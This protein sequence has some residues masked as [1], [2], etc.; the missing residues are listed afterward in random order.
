MTEGYT[1]QQAADKLGI[2]KQAMHKRVLRGTQAA[3][4]INGIWTVYLQEDTPGSDTV[5]D[6]V[7]DTGI[8]A[9]I[10]VLQS[11]IEF[12]REELKRKD[13]L[14]MTI[15]QRIPMLAAPKAEKES[16]FK[17]LFRRKE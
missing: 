16:F 8:D 11:E 13:T 9:V 2:S 15:T 17:G 3:E 12:L 10:Q 4:K 1:I 5:K 14:L 7:K 6:T